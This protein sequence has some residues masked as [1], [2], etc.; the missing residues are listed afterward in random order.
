MMELKMNV[1]KIT[2]PPCMVIVRSQLIYI[3]SLSQ[4]TH[5]ICM[6]MYYMYH[7]TPPPPSLKVMF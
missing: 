4:N 5:E 7:P 6:D 1:P 3:V 2:P